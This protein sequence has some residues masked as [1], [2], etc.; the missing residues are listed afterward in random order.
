LSVVG[1]SKAGTFDSGAKLKRAE[2]CLRSLP[3][4][5]RIRFR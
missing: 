5:N 2:S 1:A 3:E 4:H